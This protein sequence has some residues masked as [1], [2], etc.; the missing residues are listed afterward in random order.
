MMGHSFQQETETEGD[1]IPSYANYS[2]GFPT[3][4]V[5]FHGNG[6]LWI[7]DQIG[8]DLRGQLASYRVEVGG[9]DPESDSLGR[10]LA[11]ARYRFD[12]LPWLNV[13]GGAWIHRSDASTF[14][15]AQEKSTAVLTDLSLTGLRLGGRAGAD[16][17]PL[18][19]WWEFAETFGAAP[20]MTES[21]IGAD[22]AVPGVTVIGK[23]LVISGE[24][25]MS[26]RH[27]KRDVDGVPVK[28]RDNQKILNIGAGLAF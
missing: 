1:L 23:P 4:G 12:L 25:M 26:W 8:V 28:I 11:G 2:V 15:Y 17:G 27:L 21:I 16:V 9:E 19:L 13:D 24:F 10:W 14:A 20:I 5:G 6:E 3:G 7:R 18:A 22:F